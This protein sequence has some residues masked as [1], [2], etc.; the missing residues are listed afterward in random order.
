LSAT[1]SFKS[2]GKSIGVCRSMFT[3]RV[4]IALL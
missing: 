3:K 1:H 2:G 4:A